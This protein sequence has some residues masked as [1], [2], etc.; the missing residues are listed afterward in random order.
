MWTEITRAQYRRDDLPYASDTRAAEWAQI[1]PLLPSAARR[2]RPRSWHLREI[3]DAILDLLWSGCQWRAL[4]HEFPPRS[5]V[6]R[7]FYRWRDDGTFGS[8]QCRAGGAPAPAAG[9]KPDALGRH[10]R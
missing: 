6:Q 10:H 2:G 8:A 3:V 9:A 5:T 7:Y 4:P 1:A